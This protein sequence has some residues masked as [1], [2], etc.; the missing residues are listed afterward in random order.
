MEEK[1]K[2]SDDEKKIITL[3]EFLSSKIVSVGFLSRA[4]QMCSLLMFP[5]AN[6][7]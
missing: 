5:S 7:Q 2:F 4:L 6:K 1:H 3:V